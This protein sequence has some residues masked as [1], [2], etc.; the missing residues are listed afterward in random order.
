MLAG[1]SGVRYH[2]WMDIQLPLK[3]IQTQEYGWR[4]NLSASHTGP[5]NAWAVEDAAGQRL[6][7]G[8]RDQGHNSRTARPELALKRDALA[9]AAGIEALVAGE[10]DSA[11][12]LNSFLQQSDFTAIAKAR[13][14][15]TKAL[16]EPQENAFRLGVATAQSLRR[17]ATLR[18]AGPKP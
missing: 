13:L 11:P 17:K 1:P 7:G 8:L 14:G 15:Q 12:S 10:L 5:L 18:R 9:C 3:V 16:T 6:V 2:A 4:V